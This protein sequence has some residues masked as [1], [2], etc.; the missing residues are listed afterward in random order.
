MGTA[1]ETVNADTGVPN[2]GKSCKYEPG[3]AQSFGQNY[4][5]RTPANILHRLDDG[6]CVIGLCA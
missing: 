2:S 3:Q 5:I 1:W 4:R 6:M